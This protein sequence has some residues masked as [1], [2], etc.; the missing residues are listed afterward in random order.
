MWRRSC[1][2]AQGCELLNPLHGSCNVT[3][4]I[5]AVEASVATV[6]M[7]SELAFGRIRHGAEMS[8]VELDSL[9]GFQVYE[10]R[11]NYLCLGLS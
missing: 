9:E 3:T 2:S 1:K 6:N 11:R 5:P 8:Q 10:R 7:A 4:I